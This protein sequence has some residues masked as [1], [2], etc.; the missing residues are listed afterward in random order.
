MNEFSKELFTNPKINIVINDVFLAVKAIK[1][2]YF[3]FII[4]NPPI[5]ALSPELYS[6]EFY[7]EL[8]RVLKNNGK[9]YHYTGRTGILQGKNYVK[10]IIKR[11]RNVGFKNI[12]KVDEAE[13]IVARKIV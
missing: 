7:S 2:E 10:G 4:R 1:D 6:T 8:Y 9:I 13:G 12:R 3:N 5:F 11:L